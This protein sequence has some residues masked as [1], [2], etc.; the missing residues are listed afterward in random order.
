MDLL[1]HFRTQ[2]RANRLANHR[3]HRVMTQLSEAEYGA[4]RTGWTWLTTITL[5]E[6]PK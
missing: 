5:A 4:P 3:L 6:R 1:T 2:V